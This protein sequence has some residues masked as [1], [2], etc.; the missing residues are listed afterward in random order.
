MKPFAFAKLVR[1]NCRA[2]NPE[3]VKLHY[4]ILQR[5]NLADR[6]ARLQFAFSADAQKNRSCC[7]IKYNQTI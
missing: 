3:S 5:E 6:S 2:N 7:Q 1:Q 4:Y